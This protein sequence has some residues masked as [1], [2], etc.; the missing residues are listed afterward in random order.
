MT[1]QELIDEFR[2]LARDT[3]MKPPLFK[4]EHITNWLNEAQMEACIRG[5][6]LREDA[7]PAFCSIALSVGT[8]TYKLNPLV[9]EIISMWVQPGNGDEARP[10]TLRSREWMDAYMPTWRTWD[11]TQRIPSGIAIQNDT[12]IRLAGY[13]EA[14]DMLMLE[15]YRMPKTMAS[16]SDKPE[17]HEMHHLKLVQWA[18]HR[19]FSV[20]DNETLDPNRSKD[21]EKEFTKY[22]GPRPTSDARRKTRI[23]VPH[24]NV[25]PL[26]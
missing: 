18:L 5:R 17:I 7:M 4:T 2:V 24:H 13:V 12:S 16:P 23:D 8:H 14:G 11:T 15:C 3:V 25:A 1:L 6:L 19:G 21:A 26:I 22:F 9:Y 10:I 20:P